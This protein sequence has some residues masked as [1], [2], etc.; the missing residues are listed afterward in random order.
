M[1]LAP[2]RAQEAFALR[3]SQRGRAM[4]PRDFA[5][6]SLATLTCDGSARAMSKR[7]FARRSLATLTCDG[8]ARDVEARLRSK[9]L[10]T[11]GRAMSKRDFARRSLATLT[12]DGSA[13]AM[14][15]RAFARSHLRR[16]VVLFR[17]G[18][19]GG[20]EAGPSSDAGALAPPDTRSWM[21]ASRSSNK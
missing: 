6:R 11:D 20:R 10:T 1:M 16:V 17:G 12:C 18:R 9:S 2:R 8:S 5:R 19:A 3:G 14:S 13:R 15:K 21:S 7:A 4:S